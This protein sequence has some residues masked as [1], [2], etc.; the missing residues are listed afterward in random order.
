[1]PL[2]TLSA[3]LAFTV[4]ALVPGLP[5]ALLVH[6]RTDPGP[7]V[8]L[9]SALGLGLGSWLLLGIPAV[10]HGWFEQGPMAAAGLAVAVVAWVPARPHVHLLRPGRPS[11]LTAF[12]AVLAVPALWLRSDPIYFVYQVADFGEYV[13]RGNVIADGGPFGGWFVNG[14]PLMMGESHLLLGEA[15][16]TDVMPFLGLLV[17]VGVLA[18]L[19]VANVSRL[20]IAAAAVP[21]AFHVHAVWFSQFPASE[22]L[23]A[24]L[25]VFTVLFAATALVGHD[26]ATAI[27][28]G[29]FGFLLVVT[30]GNGLVYLAV[31]G[32]GL[33]LAPVFTDRGRASLLRIHFAAL[34]GALWVGTLY[35]A[36]FN[37]R[38]FLHKQAAPRLPGPLAD[39][40]VRLDE[41]VVA[42]GFTVVVAVGLV[43]A[44]VVGAWVG[45]RLGGDGP[46]GA[47]RLGTLAV[48]VGAVVAAHL[49]VISPQTYLPRYE[50]LGVLLWASV[51]LAVA[52]WL[53]R[54]RDDLDG[55][56]RFVVT[57]PLV[58]GLT[59]ATFQASRMRKS[60]TVDAPWFLYWDRYFFS[61]A[62][63]LVLLAGAAAAGVVLGAARRSARP[64]TLPAVALAGVALLGVGT[65]DMVAP[66]RHATREAMFDGAYEELAAIDALMPEPLPIVYDGLG[67]KPEGYFWSNSSR[68]LADPLT[69]T[70]EHRVLNLVGAVAPD[71]KPSDEEIRALLADV[72]STDGYVLQVTGPDGFRDVGGPELDAQVV[73]ELTLTFERL[74]GRS[75]LAPEDQRWIHTDVHVRVLRVRARAPQV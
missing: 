35:D 71:P 27:L 67:V 16:T 6:R 59:M 63:P 40:F 21:L 52:V 14:F 72:G 39:L 66:T 31:V 48:V 61:E 49:V 1:M 12:L 24:V 13:N 38:Y 29:S 68:V 11:W 26:R 33:V 36:R 50:T 44:A 37:P 54:R 7:A 58:T 46:L 3:I 73:G 74:N 4:V 55:V 56:T 62:F 53:W 75:E 17:G 64:W 8:V 2:S 18:V 43:A 42:V 9:V 65:L 47:A 20:V 10:H 25:L 15:S 19:R 30:R 70:F 22:T 32:L 69:Q 23:Y 45:R 51:V 34:G 41:P 57:W 60:M 28:A 5:L